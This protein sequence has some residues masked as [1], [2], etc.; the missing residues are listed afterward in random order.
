MGLKPFYILAVSLAAATT[1]TAQQRAADTVLKGSTIE[2]IQSY[3]PQVRKAPKPEWVPQLPPADTTRPVLTYDVPQQTLYYSYTSG[4][5]RPLALGKDSMAMPFQNYVKAGGGNLSTLFLDAGIGSLKGKDYETGI[6]LHHISQKGSIAN[7]QSALSGIEAEGTLHRDTRDWHFF[8]QGERNQYYFYGIEPIT[9]IGPTQDLKQA[10]TLVRIGGDMADRSR[11]GIG[12]WLYHPY[13]S[14]SLYSARYNNSETEFDAN[15]PVTYR[16]DSGLTFEA[17][18]SASLVSLKF[19]GLNIKNNLALIKPGVSLTKSKLSGHALLGLGYGS[20]SQFYVLPDIVANYQVAAANLSLSGGWTAS[21]RQNTYQQLTT[22]NPYLIFKYASTISGMTWAQTRIDE[23]FIK[24]SGSQ[25]KH[26]SYDIKASWWNFDKLA[27]FL[28]IIDN[29]I[30]FSVVYNDVSAISLHVGA[31]YASSNV[32]SAGATADFYKFYQGSQ[33]YVWGQ[34]TL[35]I[36]G[37]ISAA[38]I[39]K[40]AVSAY[41]AVLGGIYAIDHYGKP[42][43]LTPVTDL[44]VYGEYGI[45]DRLNVFLQASNLLNAKYERWRGYQAY[46]INVYGGLRLK[47]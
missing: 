4:A 25:G 44:G 6:H 45:T 37:D 13:V 2:V 7:Q 24:A 36:K 40:L 33:A 10:F 14:G 18:A 31:R 29:P 15:V 11:G 41:L 19:S 46:G 12:Q 34:P 16:I 39:K 22:E 23:I 20:G 47:F 3:K 32:W 21:V 35:N 43:M 30:R 8:A 5:L 27:T 1:V 17:L 26:L 28:N 42:Y 38:P 9:V